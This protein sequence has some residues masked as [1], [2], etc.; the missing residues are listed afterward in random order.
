MNDKLKHFAG[1]VFITWIATLIL[2]SLLIAA[3]IGLGAGVV[4]E[5]YDSRKGGTGFN[6]WDLFADLLGVGFAV[7]IMH[8]MSML[9]AV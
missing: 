3:L 9:I 2:D 6:T 1:C 4:K 5:L 7:A 8:S